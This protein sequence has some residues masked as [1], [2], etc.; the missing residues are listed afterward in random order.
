M[1]KLITSIHFYNILALPTIG[2]PKKNRTQQNA[3][4]L[5]TA[6]GTVCKLYINGKGRD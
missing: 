6:H 4:N 1:C 5:E 2:C 3:N